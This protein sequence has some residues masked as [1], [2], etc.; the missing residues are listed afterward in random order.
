MSITYEEA[1]Q[2]LTSMFG[3]PWTEDT[4][5]EVLRHHEGHMENTVESVLSH[6]NGDPQALLDKLNFRGT[7]SEGQSS[8]EQMQMQMAADEEMA[9]RIMQD[10]A[11]S[12]PPGLRNTASAAHSTSRVEEEV[13]SGRGTPTQLPPDFLRIAGKAQVDQDE[14]LAR[15]MQ[16]AM[17]AK[18]VKKNPEFANN[19]RLFNNTNRTSATSG[20][21]AP[22]PGIMN[23]L[24][25]MGENAKTKLSLL[26]SRFNQNK[27]KRAAANST[28]TGGA[29]GSSGAGERR[30]LLDNDLG[31]EEVSFINRGSK[32]DFELAEWTNNNT[33]RL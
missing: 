12:I 13:T 7:S 4:L 28:S 27:N 20:G 30:G 8:A 24:S 17:F 2:T 22:V 25:D 10:E 29:G 33:H 21:N 5:D 18:E 3:E 1:L 16:D 23:A 26:A 32:P 6:G 19:S 11:G 14:A 31:E 15:M 9:R